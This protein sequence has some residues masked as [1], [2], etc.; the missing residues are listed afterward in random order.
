MTSKYRE[1]D[2]SALLSLSRCTLTAV[3]NTEDQ[4]YFTESAFIIEQKLKMTHILILL[5]LVLCLREH[6]KTLLVTF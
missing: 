1:S 5:L 2:P 4:F 6:G 3:F